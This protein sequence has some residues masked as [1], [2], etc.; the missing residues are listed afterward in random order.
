MIIA[1]IGGSSLMVLGIISLNN[2]LELDHTGRPGGESKYNF[3]GHTS[4]ALMAIVTSCSYLM[5]FV[6]RFNLYKKGSK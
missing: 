1:I 3:V 4:L 2:A 5:D 6:L